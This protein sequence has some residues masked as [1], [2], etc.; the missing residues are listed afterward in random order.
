MIFFRSLLPVLAGLII[1][2]SCR[3]SRNDAA[4]VSGGILTPLTESTTDSDG[5][6]GGGSSG[7]EEQ[8][9]LPLVNPGTD[10]NILI[11]LDGNL[12]LEQSD[13]QVIVAVPLDDLEAP[14]QL[15]IATTNPI[16]NEYSIVWNRPLSVR[17]MTGITLRADDLTGNSRN[18]LVISGFNEQGQHVT[19]I[20]AVPR[21]G[22]IRDFTK[23]FG[24]S[25]DGNIDI[26][27]HERSPG[28]WSGLSSG[29]AYNIVVQQ[30]DPD[31]RNAMDI[32]ET[33][34]KWS[35]ATFSYVQGDTRQVK[36]E[37]IQEERI[38]KVYSGGV[39]PYESF[40][41]GAWYRETG[42]G[43]DTVMLFFNPR[44][45]EVMFYDGSI[46]EVFSWG[47][48]HRT[49]AK[50]LY[51]RI[52]NAVIPSMF[53]NLTVS[54][55]DWDTIELW[56]S[57]SS[58]NGVYRRFGPGLQSAADSGTFGPLIQA[59]KSYSICRASSGGKTGSR[60]SAAVPC[61]S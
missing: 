59:E 16:L 30:S 26:I 6:S 51:A 3:D 53:D 55:E 9:I 18:D 40:L 58:W 17:T 12:D 15:M 47:K 20:Y 45:R 4:P 33:D 29:K 54:A 23:V 25:V 10:Y 43:A 38:A 11:L 52:V 36:A 34:W 14:L 2:V 24:L 19:E 39:D 49:T 48:S 42:N 28:Y 35:S 32:L 61:S 37:V 27:T 8:A 1:L 22:E 21:K 13:E 44:N 46:Q 5:S 57:S 7:I 41:N 50:R 56:R 60:A 31:S